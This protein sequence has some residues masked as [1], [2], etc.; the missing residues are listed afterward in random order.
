MK[1]IVISFFCVMVA[2]LMILGITT[3]VTVNAA[4]GIL[5][6]G[7][8]LDYSTIQSAVDDAGWGDTIL[9][10]P[11]YYPES[12]TITKSNL[13]LIAQDEGVTVEPPTKPAGFHVTADRVTIRGFKI[14]FGKDCS[15]A[16]DF[17]GSFNT[18]AENDISVSPL[19]PCLGPEAIVCTDDD[20]GSDYNTIE[21]NTIYGYGALSIVSGPDALNKGNVVRDNLIKGGLW[22]LLVNN[23]TGFKISGNELYADWGICISIKADNNVPQG[24]HQIMNN[25]TQGCGSLGAGAGIQLYAFNST[26][27]T[28]NIIKANQV[29]ESF[30]SP[31][32][33][34]HTDDSGAEVS[35][36][37]IHD[38]TVY[39]DF[40]GISLG[41][42]AD[43]NLILKNLVENN[44]GAGIFISSD[45]NKVVKNKALSNIAVGIYVEGDNNLIISNTALNNVFWDLE[46]YGLDNKWLSNE[47]GTASWE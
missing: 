1:K 37:Q 44:K 12:V 26:K 42:G 7:P 4:G 28:H 40:I 34:L 19:S 8:G 22:A 36:N 38:N 3:P 23:G 24:N 18:F 29:G 11:G 27:L 10:Y 43:N 2:M 25:A 39:M 9:V 45:N 20:G 46:D 32:I 17:E 13:T 47:Y 31:G 35:H 21:N 33:Y 41:P 6:V 5:R 15:F 14:L 16:I 30:F